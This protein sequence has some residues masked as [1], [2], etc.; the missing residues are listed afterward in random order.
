MA[1]PYTTVEALRALEG[2]AR[3]LALLDYDEDGTEDAGDTSTGNVD[4]FEAVGEDT[5]TQID[6]QLGVRWEVPFADLPDTPAQ[7]QQLARWGRLAELYERLAPDGADAKKWR[8]K[9]DD[10]LAAYAK[11]KWAIPDATLLSDTATT[12]R[13][14]TYESAGTTYSGRVDDDYTDD[15]VDKN[16]GM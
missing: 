7:V 12:A 3:A 15:G 11:G 13:P 10:A 5:D 4:P 2:A 9:F 1:A 16:A 14:M 6:A 8:K